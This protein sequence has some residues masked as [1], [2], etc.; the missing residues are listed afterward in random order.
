MFHKEEIKSMD[1]VIKSF[2]NARKTSEVRRTI[3]PGN[4]SSLWKAVRIAKDT[5]INNLPNTMFKSGE[6]IQSCD[7]PDMFANF[8]DSLIPR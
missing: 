3:Q 4:C 6:E 2:Y 1:K 8:F 7:L 5:N